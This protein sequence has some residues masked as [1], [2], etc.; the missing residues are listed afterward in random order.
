M[1]TKIWIWLA[2]T[3]AMGAALAGTVACSSSKATDSVRGKMDQDITAPVVRVKQ[4]NLS[5]QLQIASEFIPYQSIDV[6]AEVSGYVKKLYVDWG[7]HVRAGQLMAVLEVPQLDAAVLRDQA[8]VSR[9]QSDLLR[10]QRMLGEAKATFFVA[11]VTYKRYADVLKQNPEL[12]SQQEVDVA[13][14]NQLKAAAGVSAAEAAVAASQQALAADEATLARDKDMDEY[15]IIRAPFDGVVTTLDAY[16][17]AL[18]PAGTSNS[19][20]SLPL[21]HLSQISL[22][23]LV[24]PVPGQLVPEVHL[25]EVVD[26][27]VPSLKRVF[28]GKISVLAGEINMQTRT[29]HTEVWVPNPDFVL[30]PGMYAYVELPIRSATHAL[31]IPVQA[32]SM[33]AQ[34]TTG[35]VL[36]VN[37]QNRIE[38]RQVTLGIQTAY[39][40]QVVSGLRAGEMVVFGEQGSY[41][42]GETVHPEPANM[43]SLGAQPGSS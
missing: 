19:T 41:H 1:N 42:A 16:T 14:G 20:A 31:A 35:T 34:G 12:I 40:V 4:E 30:V 26:V 37:A 3:G 2:A 7:S 22:L 6:D 5:N 43:A 28:Q 36:V 23:R 17:G 18:L 29:E 25:G 21:C 15:S 27:N 24:I 10:A 13:Q 38:Q 11:N 33:G 39:E 32:V 9:D 8:S